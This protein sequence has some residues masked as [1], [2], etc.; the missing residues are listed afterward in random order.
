VRLY[1]DEDVASRELTAR[2]VSAGHEV[3]APLRGEPDGR[4]WQ[5]A[6]ERGAAVLTMNAVDYGYLA[7]A[8][9]DHAGLLLLYRE[10]DP[11]LDLRAGAIV[12]AVDRIS[13]TY[14]D[15]ADGMILVVNQFRW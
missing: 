3:L 14:P 8:T 9:A 10:N 12:A 4:C 2:L 15:G 1:L 5:Y 13:Q 11:T 7:E 6:Q